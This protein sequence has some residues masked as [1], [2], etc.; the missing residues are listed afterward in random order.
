[1]N[2]NS[3]PT[4]EVAGFPGLTGGVLEKKIPRRSDFFLKSFEFCDF[5]TGKQTLF[6]SENSLR[7]P[8]GRQRLYQTSIV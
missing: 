1:M 5:V 6:S 3:N 2:G 4:L 7:K 8:K